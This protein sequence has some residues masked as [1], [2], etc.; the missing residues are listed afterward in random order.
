MHSSPPRST[1]GA[2][3]PDTA[4]FW[5][6]FTANRRFKAN[7]I[8]FSAAEG[9]HY[10]TPDGRRILDGTA[11]LWCVNAG[12]CRPEISDAIAR[13][14]R[15]L[16]YGSAFQL[17]HPRAFEFA[18]RIA[19]LAPADLN[20]VFF[21][22]SG[23]EAVD[24]ALKMALAYQQA[25]GE[26]ERVRVVGRQRGYHGMNFGGTS[27]GGNPAHR[28]PFG[29]LLASVDHLVHTYNRE[30]TAFTR[31]QPSWGGHLA[32][33]LLRI[34]AEQGAETIAAVIVEPVAG[35]T[36]VLPPP[37]G[38]LERLR[39]IC[40]Q[41][42]IVLI[43][44]EVIT[45]FGRVSK[46]FATKYYNVLPDIITCA[47]GI[48][49]GAIPMGAVVARDFIHDA[50]MH[51]P[52]NAIELPHGY[53][54]SGHPIACAAGLATLDVMEREG[55]FEG[56]A[57]LI[58]YFEDAAHSLKGIR[59]VLDIRTTGMLAAFDLAPVEGMPGKRSY[60]CHLGALEKGVLV[61]S[62]G[63]ATVISPPLIISRQ[64]IDQL[65]GTLADVLNSI[66]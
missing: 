42:G 30:Q 14:A 46:G 37:V 61:R 43:F 6:P 33:D 45:G 44:D 12:H 35:S 41:Y 60:A 9:M 29:N 36:G 31:G 66:D 51:G 18:E 40:T 34:I 23:S 65:F 25:R 55:L 38:Y 20:H 3:A 54:C 56:D 4:A 13:Q 24:T 32:D 17:G 7:P 11:G 62:A 48:N 47:K 28:R 5:M 19:Q 53:T 1:P 21:T 64:Q 52:V 10:I 16:D 50:L 26:T 2:Q 57:G 58:R 59:H 49:N 8:I 22:N 39:E 15:E 27:V 63:D